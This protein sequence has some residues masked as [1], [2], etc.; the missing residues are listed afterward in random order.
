MRTP[1]PILSPLVV[2]SPAWHVTCTLPESNELRERWV[3]RDG[4]SGC[5]ADGVNTTNSRKHFGEGC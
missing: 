4:L 3:E 5:H 2:S 1:Q